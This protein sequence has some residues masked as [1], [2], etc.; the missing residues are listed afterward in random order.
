MEEKRFNR[1]LERYK[2]SPEAVKELYEYYYPI[3][4]RYINRQ[5]RGEVDGQDVAQQFFL[6]L[7][8]MKSYIPRMK[9][10]SRTKSLTKTKKNTIQPRKKL[11]KHMR[12][13]RT[14]RK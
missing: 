8:Q 13:R 3:I 10:I 14:P 9:N 5:F 7:F 6:K 1:L 11:K 12:V 4:V 2:Y